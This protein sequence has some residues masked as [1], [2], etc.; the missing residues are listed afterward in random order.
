MIHYV[1]KEFNEIVSKDIKLAISKAFILLEANIRESSPQRR[2]T[3]RQI[4]LIRYKAI[5]MEIETVSF[6]RSQMKQI[7]DRFVR[8]EPENEQT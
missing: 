6:I 5:D 2:L 7:E 4:D 3:E 8:K 1:D